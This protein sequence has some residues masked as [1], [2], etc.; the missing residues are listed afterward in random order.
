MGVGRPPVGLHA[1][2]QRGDVYQVVGLQYKQLCR[3]VRRSAVGGI[4]VYQIDLGTCIQLVAEGGKGGVGRRG[5][6]EGVHAPVGI[7]R[8]RTIQMGVCPVRQGESY[9]AGQGL[10]G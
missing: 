9:L 4:Y 1:G 6:A 7:A 2:T 10:W 8:Y 3:R 5:I